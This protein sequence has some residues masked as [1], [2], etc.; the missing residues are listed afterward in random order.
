MTVR[1]WNPV[2]V[3]GSGAALERTAKT[4]GDQARCIDVRRLETAYGG[5]VA[6]EVVRQVVATNL[7]GCVCRSRRRLAG[8]RRE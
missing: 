2:L 8:R 1:K 7:E 3:I 5:A 4:V 6:G